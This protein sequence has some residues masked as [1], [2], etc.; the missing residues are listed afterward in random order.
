MPQ[1]GRFSFT[2]NVVQTLQ[3]THSRLCQAVAAALCLVVSAC[4]TDSGQVSSTVGAPV[5][6]LERILSIGDEDDSDGIIFGSI[7]DLVAVDGTG[8]IFVGDRQDPKI[9]AFTAEG[10]LI[11]TIGSKG[12]GPGEFN[13][14]SEIN[15]GRGDTLY[16]FDIT[17]ARISVFDPA[18]YDFAY[19]I[20]ISEDPAG[21]SPSEFTGVLDAGIIVTYDEPPV[22]GTGY[23]ERFMS[24]RLV[25]WAGN[26]R[27]EPLAQV[28]S[29]EWMGVM[30]SNTLSFSRKPYARA[31]IFRLGPE[32]HIYSGSSGAL[33]IAISTAGGALLGNIAHPMEAL[34]ITQGEMDEYLEN[35]SEDMASRMRRADLHKTKPAYSTFRVDDEGRTWVR[36][37]IA[38][39]EASTSMWLVL[40]TD[41]RVV[42]QT[43]VPSSVHL[44][45]ISRRKA[46]AVD[47]SEGVALA[48]YEIRG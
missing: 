31:P 23:E 6:K 24:A 11:A 45:V 37:T 10:E 25:S 17:L 26:V 16:A 21:N 7:F 27:E 28:P 38:D 3:Q 12:E 1:A 34:S 43:I 22:P 5:I 35:F 36:P 48:V 40:D 39:P 19:A 41:S 15:I 47:T 42:G 29:S 44:Q 2:R 46:Y 18:S 14:L 13:R 8:R 32:G 20:T 30:S 4:S 9:C 33:D